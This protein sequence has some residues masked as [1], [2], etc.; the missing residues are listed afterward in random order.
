MEYTQIL[1]QKLIE[2]GSW[3]EQGSGRKPEQGRIESETD[4]LIEQIAE[5]LKE[6]EE[7]GTFLPYQQLCISLELGEYERLLLCLLW[8]HSVKGGH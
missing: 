2:I 7:T 3:L 4:S 6:A 1:N 5:I 8:Y